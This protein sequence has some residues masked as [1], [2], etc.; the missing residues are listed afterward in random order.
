MGRGGFAMAENKGHIELPPLAVARCVLY[1][2]PWRNLL[3]PSRCPRKETRAR[4]DWSVSSNR[5]RGFSIAEE[6]RPQRTTVGILRR[7]D[8]AYVLAEAEKVLW[9]VAGSA[10]TRATAQRQ[11]DQRRRHTVSPARHRYSPP[12]RSASILRNS[13]YDIGVYL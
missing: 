6:T 5:G 1:F 7:E 11:P 13:T 12:R 2:R 4:L 3:D 10:A 8:R 9:A